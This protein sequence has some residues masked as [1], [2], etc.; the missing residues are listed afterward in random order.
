MLNDEIKKKR[1]KN[2]LWQLRLTFQTHDIGR[3]IKITSFK[4]NKNKL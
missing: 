4:E 2:N 3:K 1:Q